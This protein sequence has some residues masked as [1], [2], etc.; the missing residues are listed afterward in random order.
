MWGGSYAGFDQWATAKE[1]PPHLTTIVPAAAAH[2][3]LD[4]PFTNNVG[5]SYAVFC[6]KKKNDRAS[7][8]NLF[9][10]STFSRTKF[11]DA[12]KQHIHFKTLDRFIGNPSANYQR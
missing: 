8:Q 4:F 7:Q 1:L 11:L 3:G 5:I 9:G 2:P 10:D 12:Y 6:L